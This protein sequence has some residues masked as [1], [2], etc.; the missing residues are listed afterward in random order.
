MITLGLK[1]LVLLGLDAE[2]LLGESPSFV[3]LNDI[4]DT[5]FD[6]LLN[7]IHGSYESLRVFL[8]FVAWF[9]CCSD[10]LINLVKPLLFLA[11]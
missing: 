3:L 7:E 4:T 5:V 8:S 10:H 11:T 1:L 9:A 2:E 6:A